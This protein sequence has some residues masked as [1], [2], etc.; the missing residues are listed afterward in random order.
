[1]LDKS[2]L[3]ERIREAVK[4]SDYALRVHA[5]RHMLSGGFDESDILECIESGKILENYH[6]ENRGLISGS[7]HTS[8]HLRES[9]HVVLDY[10]SESGKIDWIDLVTAYIP[11]PPFWETPYRRGRKR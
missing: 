8:E 11:R 4:R 3:L 9:L 1:M 7:F 6:E 10:W 5:V 2:A